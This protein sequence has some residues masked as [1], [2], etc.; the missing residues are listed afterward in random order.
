MFVCAAAPVLADSEPAVPGP[1]K[2]AAVSVK[3]APTSN[4][5]TVKAPLQ[6]PPKSTS[7]VTITGAQSLTAAVAAFSR[8]FGLTI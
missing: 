7:P 2:T 1:V 4:V 3:Q 5:S 6:T 8:I